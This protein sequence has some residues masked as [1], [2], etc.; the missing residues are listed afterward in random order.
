MKV[1]LNDESRICIDEGNKLENLSGAIEMKHKVSCLRK[2]SKIPKLFIIECCISFKEPGK[3][4]I[5]TLTINANC[6]NFFDRKLVWFFKTIMYLATEQRTIKTFFM[7]AYK[8][9]DMACEQFRST[10]GFTKC[11]MRRLHPGKK[12]Y[13][14]PLGKVGTTLITNI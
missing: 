1:I 3:I 11:S 2:T 14:L 10:F 13:K 8:T 7:K 5:I 9:T 4:T 12:I 6:H